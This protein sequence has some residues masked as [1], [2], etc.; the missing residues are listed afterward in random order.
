MARNEFLVDVFLRWLVGFML[1]VV[2]FV[3][4]QVMDS[5]LYELRGEFIWIVFF[6][7]VILPSLLWQAWMNWGR[8][9]VVQYIVVM[10]VSMALAFWGGRF[11]DDP[12]AWGLII[13]ILIAPAVL[14]VWFE[15][16]LA[17]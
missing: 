10:S 12:G 17:D 6:H 4:L 1:A 13:T 5:T 3:T 7:L 14:V 8:T 15:F 9:L 2:V 16:W 11:L